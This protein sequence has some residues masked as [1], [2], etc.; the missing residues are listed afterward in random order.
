MP[1]LPFFYDEDKKQI[2]YGDVTLN[3]I[4]D[5]QDRPIKLVEQN[6]IYKPARNISL[7]VLDSPIVNQLK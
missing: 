4:V 1:P 7:T 6:T 2:K 3:V 5:E